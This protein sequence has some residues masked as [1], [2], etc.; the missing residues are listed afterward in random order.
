MKPNIRVPTGEYN[1][2]STYVLGVDP[3]RKG[4]DE[5]GFVILEQLPFDENIF[6]VFVET[7]HT[8][9]TRVIRDR[10][11]QLDTIFNFKKIIVDETG[12]GSIVDFIREVCGRKVEGIWYTQK[13]KAEMFYN[14]KL[15]MTRPKGK[16]YIPDYLYQKKAILK[17]MYFQFLSIT[18]EFPNEDATRTPKISHEEREHDD[19]VNAIAL[20]SSYFNIRQTKRNYILGRGK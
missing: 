10:V 5:T 16:L 8:P 17:K 1:P 9:D 18:I 12:L 19:I 6:V 13:S 3:A 2:K 14:L 20:A 11:A 15:L 4:K 7:S